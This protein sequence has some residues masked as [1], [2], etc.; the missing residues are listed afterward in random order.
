MEKRA[1]LTR[2]SMES[3]HKATPRKQSIL[4]CSVWFTQDDPRAWGCL[5]FTRG[6][7][8]RGQR[9]AHPGPGSR[10]I[11]SRVWPLPG[12]RCRWMP[13]SRPLHHGK[14][15]TLEKTPSFSE[16]RIPDTPSFLAMAPATRKSSDGELTTSPTELQQDKKCQ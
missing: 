12:L 2:K 6:D 13:L 14:S 15:S 1:T 4:S 11:D 7:A 16:Y 3:T 5:R 10:T 9:H 8:E